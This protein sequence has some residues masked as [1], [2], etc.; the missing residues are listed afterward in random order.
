MHVYVYVYVCTRVPRACVSMLLQFH[1][2]RTNMC[3]TKEACFFTKTLLSGTGASKTVPILRRLSG[4]VWH[5]ELKA[6]PPAG[7]CVHHHEPDLASG[8]N[9]GKYLRR[10][11]EGGRLP[12][13]SFVFVVQ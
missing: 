1:G 2:A 10:V 6:A 11:V 3:F 4:P 5:G 9:M 8:V 7:S 13:C 12:G